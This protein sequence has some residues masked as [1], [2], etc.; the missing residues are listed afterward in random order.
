M[1]HWTSWTLVF[2]SNLYACGNISFE[3]IAYGNS[4]CCYP[5]APVSFD[6]SAC[7]LAEWTIVLGGSLPLS[8]RHV[9]SL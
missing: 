9:V 6:V 4:V 7:I 1:R 2:F 5:R 3:N 8:G